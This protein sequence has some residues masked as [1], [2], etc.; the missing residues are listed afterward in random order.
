[1]NDSIK[2]FLQNSGLQQPTFAANSRYA[3]MET[4]EWTRA[5]GLPVLY[6]KQRFSP[7][8]E[9]FAT[10]QENRVE[11]NDQSANTAAQYFSAPEMVAR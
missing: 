2:A 10:L 1:M 4:A 11:T 8:P 9:N 5:D 7:S 3:G 6:V